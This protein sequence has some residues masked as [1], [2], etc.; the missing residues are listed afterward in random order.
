MK[1]EDTQ[2]NCEE[3][4]DC[5]HSSVRAHAQPLLEEDSWT[6]HYGGGEEHV[7]DGRDDGRVVNVQGF[8]EIADLDAD[9]DHQADE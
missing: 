1:E 9:A 8:I 6:C 4:T 5:P 7:I 3:P 2:D